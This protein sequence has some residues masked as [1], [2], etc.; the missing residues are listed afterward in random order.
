MLHVPRHNGDTL[1]RSAAY[2]KT[3]MSLDR[4]CHVRHVQRKPAGSTRNGYRDETGCPLLPAPN[5]EQRVPS[6][7]SL[8]GKVGSS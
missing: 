7:R 3:P 6:G 4:Q 5:G 8:Q 1:P 2:V